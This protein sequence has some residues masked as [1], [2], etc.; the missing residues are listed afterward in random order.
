MKAKT[1][2]VFFYKDM[3]HFLKR[4]FDNIIDEYKYWEKHSTTLPIHESQK[5]AD[6]IIMTIKRI[7]LQL[8]RYEKEI[9]ML[10]IIQ[11]RPK[12]GKKK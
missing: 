3:L 2:S 1:R 6:R 9:D 10:K 8:N 5:I 4:E 7:E 12:R 11:K